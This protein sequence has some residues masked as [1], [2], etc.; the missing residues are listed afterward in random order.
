VRPGRLEIDRGTTR[1]A[2]DSR[3]TPQKVKTT[4]NLISVVNRL[5]LLGKRLSGSNSGVIFGGF[6]PGALTIPRS[7]QPDLPAD[8]SP[9]LSCTRH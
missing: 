3:L 2:A 7:L 4:R 5:D 1:F 8:S 6:R 9:S